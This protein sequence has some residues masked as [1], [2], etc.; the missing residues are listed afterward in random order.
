[1]V[2]GP[3]AA[4]AIQGSAALAGS[5]KKLKFDLGNN[6]AMIVNSDADLDKALDI[7]LTAAFGCDAGQRAH[8]L[9][10][11][12]LHKVSRPSRPIRTSQAVSL[13]ATPLD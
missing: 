6:H 7:A 3:Q 10:R 13:L 8:S 1:M 11:L 4:A 2:G 5:F 12:I 9:G